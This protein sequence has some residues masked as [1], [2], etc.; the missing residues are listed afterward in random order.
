MKMSSK[1]EFPIVQN[2]PVLNICLFRNL[3]SID[4][5]FND[6]NYT[7]QDSQGAIINNKINA[8]RTWRLKIKECET[9]IYSY[10]LIVNESH[11]FM[12]NL[13]I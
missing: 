1:I 5:C 13:R 8:E 3:D 10:Y 7:I 9:A 4:I 6:Q 12:K 11:Q 2:Q